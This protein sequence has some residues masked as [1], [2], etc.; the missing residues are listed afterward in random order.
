MPLLDHFH[1][2]LFPMRR[3]EG[4]HNAWANAI[5]GQ[6]SPLLPSEYFA[7]PLTTVGGSIEIDVATLRQGNGP[8]P[9][10]SGGT[11]AVVWT[12]PRPL[13]TLPV[14]FPKQDAFEVRVYQELDGPRLRAAV[15]LVSPANK[16]RP[17]NRRTF[18][19]KC[20]AYLE[21]GVA[22]VVVDIVTN[23]TANFHAEI[24]QALEA[25]E[26]PPWRSPTDLYTIAYRPVPGAAQSMLDTWPEALTLGAPLPT[27]PLWLEADLCLPLRLE[28]SYAATCALLRI[29]A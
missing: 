11:P 20:A 4:F 19:D 24:L 22:V 8:T 18:V 25:R 27:L 7:E 29:R 5:V 10:S 2:P 23:R 1:P 28:E 21:H 17:L 26:D 13:Q 15:E 6:L 3:R 14:T 12:P 9:G 16:D